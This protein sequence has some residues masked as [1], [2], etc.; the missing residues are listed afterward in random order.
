MKLSRYLFL[1]IGLVALT[2]AAAV[3]AP[4]LP[5]M[6]VETEFILPALFASVLAVAGGSMVAWL[7]INELA[8]LAR[9]ELGELRPPARFVPPQTGT[10]EVTAFG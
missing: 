8:A 7:V 4:A 2:C 9:V 6:N 5:L 10:P 3:S 1:A